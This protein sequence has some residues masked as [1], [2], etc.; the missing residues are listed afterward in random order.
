MLHLWFAIVAVS[1]L[2]TAIAQSYDA[3]HIF[4][5]NDYARA[6]PFYTAHHLNVGYIEA[7]VFLDDG[8][9]VV[10]HHKHEIQKEKT[11]ETLYLKPLLK[12]VLKNKGSVYD[13]RSRTLTLMIDLKT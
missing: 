1:L 5:H 7:D 6:I 13:D 2:N 9:I 11:L 4:A 10:A 12:A 3:S 8:Q